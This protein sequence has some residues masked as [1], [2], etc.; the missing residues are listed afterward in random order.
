[1]DRIITKLSLRYIL[2]IWG[3]KLNSWKA[4]GLQVSLHKTEMVEPREFTAILRHTMVTHAYSSD[5]LTFKNK[6][7]RQQ[8]L[9]IKCE[10]RFV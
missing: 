3:V 10:P 6:I 8:P 9:D 5:V 2:G 7:L 1:M 4:V